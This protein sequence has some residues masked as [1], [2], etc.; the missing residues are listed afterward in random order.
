MFA[1]KPSYRLTAN[2]GFRSAAHAIALEARALPALMNPSGQYS[3]SIL[4]ESRRP[5][6]VAPYVVSNSA[7]C[8]QA[9]SVY[10]VTTFGAPA[11]PIVSPCPSVTVTGAKSRLALALALELSTAWAT[12]F[13][14]AWY[15]PYKETMPISTA[16]TTTRLMAVSRRRLRAAAASASR[17][18]ISRAFAPETLYGLLFLVLIGSSSSY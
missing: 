12:G 13:F 9:T 14:V 1:K 17:C 15:Q 18:A 2:F 16:T 6:S 5:A 11:T 7:Q 3:M 10:K 8:V 4:P